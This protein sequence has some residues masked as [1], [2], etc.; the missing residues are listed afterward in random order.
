MLER[1]QVAIRATDREFGFNAFVF[2]FH[3]FNTLKDVD[4]AAESVRE[5]LKA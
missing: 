3:E 1:H 5:E 4:R 2:S